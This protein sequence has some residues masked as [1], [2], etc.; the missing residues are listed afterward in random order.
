MDDCVFCR[1]IDGQIPAAVL[2]ETDQVISFLD[3]NPINAGHA[4]VVPKRHVETLLGLT[5]DEL[6]ATALV[7]R[8]VAAAVI[9]ATSS[10]AFHVLQNNG[11]SAGQVVKHVHFHVIPRRPDDGFTLGWRQTQ[12]AAGQLAALQRAIQAL[13]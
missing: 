11:E 6:H 7:T 9:E 8:R 5:N 3:I 10:P 1:I 12:P 4:L 13:L 2:V